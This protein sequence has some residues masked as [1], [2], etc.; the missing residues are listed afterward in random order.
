MPIAWRYA[1][2]AAL[3]TAL[4]IA[5]QDLA[6]RLYAGPAALPAA[7]LAGTAA[8]LLTKY[9]LDK[10]YIFGW[11]AAS[12]RDDSRRF[13]RYAATGVGTT[14]LFWATEGLFQ[15]LWGTAA[16][17]YLGATLG[18]G[19]GYWAKYRLDGRFVFGS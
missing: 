18:L 9:W 1:L 6:T 19:L 11:R 14:L 10:H 12:L 15:L 3:A 5:T 7:V 4:N 16:M 13:L 8:G 2:F 17:R